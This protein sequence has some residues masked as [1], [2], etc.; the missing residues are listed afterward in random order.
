M[1]KEFVVSVPHQLSKEEA[2]ERIRGL[3]SQLRK[4]YGDQ[5]SDVEEKWSGDRC[6]FSLRIRR[7]KLAGSI[8]VRSSSAEI[9]GNLPFAARMFEGQARKLIEQRARE[10]L[11]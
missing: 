5:V 4:E 9:R 3:V 2:I 11:A 7:M 8:Q 1:A 6:E 10:L